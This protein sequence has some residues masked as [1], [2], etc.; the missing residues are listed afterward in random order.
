MK[1]HSAKQTPWLVMLGLLLSAI[2]GLVPQGNAMGAALANVPWQHLPKQ[3]VPLF[4]PSPTRTPSPTTTPACGLAWRSV[5]CPNPFYA[6]QFTGVDFVSES[7][8]WAVGYMGNNGQGISLIVHWDGSEWSIVPSPNIPDRPTFLNGIAVVSS[9]DIWAV[10]YSGAYL[11]GY[12][13]LIMHWDGTL[14]SIVPS[15]SVGNSMLK[16]VS[17]VAWNDIWAV[18]HDGSTTNG[19]NLI[20]HFDGSQWSVVPSP[21]AS[22]IEDDLRGVSAVSANDVWAVGE[23]WNDTQQTRLT[24][25]LH[26]NGSAWSIM[27]SPNEGNI[28]QLFGVEA[29]STN[30]IWAVEIGRASC[31]ERV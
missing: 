4:T 9:D 22:A 21:N 17:A 26:W 23:Y 28:A 20:L 7:D 5:T 10:G 16:S 11:L 8:V 12:Q 2:L 25:T 14:W 27:P 15:P 30:D 29:I 1:K 18:G 13:T 6:N 24:L 3:N 19:Q 31:R